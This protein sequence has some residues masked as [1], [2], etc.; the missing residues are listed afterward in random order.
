M[1][2]IMLL[3]F[4]LTT[5]FLISLVSAQYDFLSY[6]YTQ[7]ILDI[8]KIPPEF[9]REGNII[10]NVIFRLLVPFIAIWTIILGFL[11]TLRIFPRSPGLETIISFT[12][13]FATLPT[14]A[15]IALVGFMLAA[16]GIWSVILFFGMF[17]LGATLYAWNWG[18]S[19]REVGGMER[20]LR[21]LR[22]D[23]RRIDDDIT[24]LSRDPV[25]NKD[26]IKA[27]KAE[28]E[29][30]QGQIDRYEAEIQGVASE[31]ARRYE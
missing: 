30:I 14:G 15:F 23:R 27:K 21:G 22:N 16:A 1:Q 26:A 9:I 29:A 24:K 19:F 13:A 10:S 7:Y 31:R 8:L 12:M 28:R 3:S 25:T 6:P 2:K 20:K 18:G 17:I 11:R 5:I 4:L